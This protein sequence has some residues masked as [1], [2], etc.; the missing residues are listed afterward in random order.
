[1]FTKT[2]EAAAEM[3]AAAFAEAAI[4]LGLDPEDVLDDL[5][6]SGAFADMVDGTVVQFVA[7]AA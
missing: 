7:V 2:H 1:M 3:F 5:T 6:F 4:S